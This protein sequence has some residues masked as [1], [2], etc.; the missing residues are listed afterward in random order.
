M[1]DSG[2]HGFPRESC[3]RAGI[4]GDEF[5]VDK[6][7]V[8]AAIVGDEIFE[9]ILTGTEGVC[10]ALCTRCVAV[11]EYPYVAIC[12]LRCVFEVDSVRLAAFEWINTRVKVGQGL[13]VDINTYRV[14]CSTTSAVFVVLHF[15]GV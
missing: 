13:S 7:V 14:T 3:H 6:G 2:V 12:K 5:A 1:H 8:A 4:D 9:V 11:S 10:W 15:Y